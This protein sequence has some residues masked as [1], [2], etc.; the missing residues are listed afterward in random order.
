MINILG[1]FLTPVLLT[2]LTVLICLGI[3]KAPSI[4][5]TDVSAFSGFEAG[6]SEGYSTMDLFAAFFFSALIFKQIEAS[7]KFKEHNI[8]KA[9][10]IP[11]IMG[12]AILAIVYFGF[13]FLGAHYAFV[14]GDVSLELALPAIAKYLLGE[15]GGWFIAITITLSCF[16]TAIALNNIYARYICASWRNGEKHFSKILFCTTFLSFLVSLLDFNGIAR[17]LSPLLNV[18]YPALIALTLLCIF[19]KGYKTLK[20]IIFYSIIL[21]A[22]V[23]GI[24]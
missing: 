11:S 8:I 2:F 23:A 1:K 10:L 24:S 18:S 3:Y 21:L 12:A 9:A 15:A 4:T 6:F 17:I 20:A 5:N 14:A 7:S 19:F 16:T 13:V 22:V